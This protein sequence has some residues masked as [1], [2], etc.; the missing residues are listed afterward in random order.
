MI[1]TFGCSFAMRLL[2]T[3]AL[4]QPLKQKSETE[5]SRSSLLSGKQL[6]DAIDSSV[7][8]RGLVSGGTHD[9]FL[10]DL[11]QHWD[12]G[13]DCH[14]PLE[15]R[16]TSSLFR[17]EV[18]TFLMFLKYNLYWTMA[19]AI[20]LEV[21]TVCATGGGT[22][23]VWA[24]IPSP[25][26]DISIPPF[27]TACVTTFLMGFMSY[28]SLATTHLL[29]TLLLAPFYANP[30]KSWPLLLGNPLRATSIHDFWSYQWHSLFRHSYCSTGGDL[31][32][33]VGGRA[34]AVLGVFLA[35]GIQHDFATWCMGQGTE[36]SRV[37]AYFLIQGIVLLLE[38]TFDIDIW[39]E[40]PDAKSSQRM[41]LKASISRH[42]KGARIIRKNSLVN[43]GLG[44]IWTIFWVILPATLMID[45]WARRGLLTP[46]VSV[47][48][49]SVYFAR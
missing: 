41:T 19:Y 45:V 37:T 38:K 39:I 48:P 24:R 30:A 29:F 8:L 4:N 14:L 33:K 26:G 22:I 18:D 13:H 40:F 49:L 16:N 25:L 5:C 36:P 32:W 12:L 11:F 31:G 23:F 1:G 27:F 43:N 34:G 7:D 9:A 35:S 44:K 28:S 15:T 20:L 10:P 47:T 17:F 21:G 6:L 2:A 3:A 46:V 42:K